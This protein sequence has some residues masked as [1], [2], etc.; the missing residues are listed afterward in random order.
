MSI[1]I[2]VGVCN[3]SGK[4]INAFNIAEVQSTFYNIPME[5]TVEKWREKAGED[6]IFSFKVF[7]GI[8]HN[9][10]SRTWRRY[11][12]QL[13]ESERK[14]VGDLKL[15]D[16][17]KGYWLQM[18]KIANVLKAMFMVIQT[19]ASFKPTKENQKNFLDT[20]DFLREESSTVNHR[21][22][23]VWEPRG[24][25]LKDLNILTSLLKETEDV[26]HCVDPLFHDPV[27]N[28]DKLYFRLHGMPYLNYKY[29]YSKED[30]KSLQAKIEKLSDEGVKH[31]YIL[32]NNISMIEDAK[33][34]KDFIGD[35]SWKVC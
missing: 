27:V 16:V 8:T 34:F 30:F 2:C 19:P 5:K 29:K 9:Y 7:Q 35:T 32:F 25:W 20:I 6:F 14:L 22:Y 17:T 10:K 26:I 33:K 1:K 12:G 3:F 18:F 28:G 24:D 4:V 31:Y 15:N 13:S 23:I 21:I 11:R